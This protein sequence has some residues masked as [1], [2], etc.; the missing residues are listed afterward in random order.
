MT[1]KLAY[2][3]QEAADMLGIHRNTVYEEVHHGRIPSV[4]IGRAIRIPADGLQKWLA[5][6]QP[7]AQQ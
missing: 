4:R 1:E 7:T 6:Q 2:T 3:V 5:G